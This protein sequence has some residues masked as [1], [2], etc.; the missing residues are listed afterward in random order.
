[1]RGIRVDQAVSRLK[2]VSDVLFQVLVYLLAEETNLRE[3]Q[4]FCLCLSNSQQENNKLYL[5]TDTRG[6]L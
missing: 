4:A 3:L 2:W 1:M 5:A 6:K